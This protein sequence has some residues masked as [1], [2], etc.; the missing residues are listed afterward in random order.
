[1]KIIQRLADPLDPTCVPKTESWVSGGEP[2]QVTTQKEPG[3]TV[4]E[5]C[6][7]HEEAIAA[8]ERLWPRD[9]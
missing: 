4:D 5:W 8:A 1:M 3:E 7:A 6:K 2:V 9:D